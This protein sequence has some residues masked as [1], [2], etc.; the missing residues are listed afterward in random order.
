[1]RL[2]LLGMLLLGG[3]CCGP[4][5]EEHWADLSHAA[6]Q[7]AEHPATDLG[8]SD[9]TA[10]D[11][12]DLGPVDTQPPCV[13]A[14]NSE[15]LAQDRAYLCGMSAKICANGSNDVLGWNP[16]DLPLV[17]CVQE[18]SLGYFVKVPAC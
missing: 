7:S 16:V 4:G 5:V 10:P 1:L 11:T 14:P 17:T 13:C 8:P 18:Q 12:T 9:V 6:D 2:R 3:I 15:H